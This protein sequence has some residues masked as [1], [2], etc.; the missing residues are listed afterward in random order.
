METKTKTNADRIRNM[1]DE[2]LAIFFSAIDCCNP[3]PC[4]PGMYCEKCWRDWLG[5]EAE[6][7]P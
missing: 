2:E 7:K 6:E 4:E 5:S 3:K 1:S